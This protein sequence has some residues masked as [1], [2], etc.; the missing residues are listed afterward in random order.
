MLIGAYDPTLCSIRGVRYTTLL[1]GPSSNLLA[2][3]FGGGPNGTW[4]YLSGVHVT[5]AA[6]LDRM[7]ELAKMAG[8][9][10]LSELEHRHA[11]VQQGL[12]E[13]LLTSGP[14]SNGNPYFVMS[15]EPASGL[16]HGKIGQMDLRNT[17]T[18]HG[19]FEPS[20]NHDA[21]FLRVVNDTVAEVRPFASCG[22]GHCCGI[23]SGKRVPMQGSPGKCIPVDL[24]PER[25]A[26]CTSACFASCRCAS[27]TFLGSLLNLYTALR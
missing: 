8:H 11:L 13:H 16:L 27:C 5:Y 20:P 3:S 22:N 6:A 17:K 14:E 19:Y 10:M 15:K 1:T 12:A 2:P 23:I 18:L 24:P 21:V 26:V 7:I 4:S 9:P 25:A